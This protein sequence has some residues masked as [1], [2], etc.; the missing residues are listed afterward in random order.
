MFKGAFF[1]P[2]FRS[3]FEE[4]SSDLRGIFCTFGFADYSDFKNKVGSEKY[5]NLLFGNS[6]SI[7]DGLVYGT[8]KLTYLGNNKVS[9]SHDIY[10]FDAKKWESGTFIRNAETMLGKLK[11]PFS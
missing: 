1:G 5:F 10:D 7:N 2:F 9:A 6:H 4:F 11:L 3:G 8:I